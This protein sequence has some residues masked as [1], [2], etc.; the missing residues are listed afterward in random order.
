MLLCIYVRIIE[1][2]SFVLRLDGLYYKKIVSKR[3]R[4]RRINTR[5][6]LY[7]RVTRTHNTHRQIII[8]SVSY[9]HYGTGTLREGNANELR[10]V[11]KKKWYFAKSFF[12]RQ[13]LGRLTVGYITNSKLFAEFSMTCD[14]TLA[15]ESYRRLNEIDI[16]LYSR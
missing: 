3:I 15:N 5:Y 1:T 11:K 4:L 16:K 2:I 13:I 8:I 12:D 6:K 7:S 10:P 9:C 14:I